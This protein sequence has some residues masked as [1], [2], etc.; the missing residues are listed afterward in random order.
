MRVAM[1][2]IAGAFSQLKKARLVAKLKA[3]FSALVKK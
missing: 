1:R 2:Q 3:L